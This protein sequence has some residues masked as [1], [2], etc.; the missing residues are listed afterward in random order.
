MT[1]NQKH[2]FSSDE[3][4]LAELFA[5]LIIYLKKN[6]KLI[7]ICLVLG[8]L[9][10]IVFFLIAPK[11]YESKMLISS[12]IL[13]ESYSKMMVDDLSK[14]IGEKNSTTLSVKLGLSENLCASLTNVEI[15]S[16]IEKSEFMKE[17]EKNYLTIICQSKN[18][19]IWPE[20]QAG[21]ISFFESNDFVKTRVE[22]RKKYITE[23]IQK[24][25]SELKDLNELK[26]RIVNGQ[27]T[28]SSKDNL[29]LF[30]PTTVNTKILELNKEKINLQNSLETVNSIQLV[31][32]F[33]TF[34]SAA[35]PKLS[36]SVAG[37][38]LSGILIALLLLLSR[39]LNNIVTSSEDRV[40]NS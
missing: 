11:K 20:L 39:S 8:I 17:Q 7:I 3:I 26:A 22:H 34:M 24:I 23:I 27:L 13:T 5:K 4:D 19:T 12:D 10:G 6:S 35:S 40:S 38:A 29:V 2:T 1:E 9:S 14:L 21:L 16:S 37:G 31:E 36:F 33:T 15:K 28:Q 18:N 32:G 30:D 25:D